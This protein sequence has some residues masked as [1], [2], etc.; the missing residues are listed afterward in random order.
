MGNICQVAYLFSS[1]AFLCVVISHLHSIGY[2]LLVLLVIFV[3]FSKK[4]YIF[5]NM[6]MNS[7]SF[8]TKLLKKLKFSSGDDCPVV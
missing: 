7:Y 1:P 6:L 5:P 3:N 4:I 8:F 2:S